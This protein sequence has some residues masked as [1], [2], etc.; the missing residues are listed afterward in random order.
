MQRSLAVDR[1]LRAT[2]N[3]WSGLCGAAQ[4][5]AAVREELVAIAL[6]VPLAFVVAESPLKRLALIALV[7]FT[8]VFDLLNPPIENLADEV[9]TA[10]H[11]GIRGVKDMGSAAVSIA[12]LVAAS[13][14]LAAI[15]ERLAFW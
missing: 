1:L 11:P 6:A 10:P 13:V 5:E 7:L 8:L 14:W 15:G 9:A 3:S 4:S 2:V 12:V